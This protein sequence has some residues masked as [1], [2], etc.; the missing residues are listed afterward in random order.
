VEASERSLREALALVGGRPIAR[1]DGP[2]AL[3]FF[4][5]LPMKSSD[6]PIGISPDNRWLV[7]GSPDK[8]ARPW[9]LSAKDPGAKPIVLRGH[10]RNTKN[11]KVHEVFQSTKKSRKI[12]SEIT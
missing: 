7:T 4:G 9:D 12:I 8:T 1:A 11:L 2:I 6:G 3:A 5:V 10:V